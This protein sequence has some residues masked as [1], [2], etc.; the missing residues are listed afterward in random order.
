[1]VGGY[2][3]SSLD[4]MRQLSL[5]CTRDSGVLLNAVDDLCNACFDLQAVTEAAAGQGR[6]EF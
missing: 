1:M 5:Q 3:V 6:A 2:T 4:R